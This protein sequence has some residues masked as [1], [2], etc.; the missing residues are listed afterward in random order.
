MTCRCTTT[1]KHGSTHEAIHYLF[2]VC[3]LAK[4]LLRAGAK[5][6]P[7][8][9][10]HTALWVLQCGYGSGQVDGIL[11]MYNHQ[12]SPAWPLSGMYAHFCV[13]VEFHELLV[14]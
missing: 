10:T 5:Q 3:A 13:W 11:P 1:V 14:E 6:A 2:G 9:L 4:Q 12:G 7:I 8:A